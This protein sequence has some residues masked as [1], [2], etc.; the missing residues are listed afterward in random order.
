[1]SC[2]E[3]IYVLRNLKEEMFLTLTVNKI[4]SQEAKLQAGRLKS[5]MR[6]NF[7]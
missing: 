6:T 1:M 5:D 2:Q 4:R 3:K 7:L